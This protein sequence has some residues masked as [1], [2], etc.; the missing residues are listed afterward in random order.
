MHALVVE[1]SLLV[2]AGFSSCGPPGSR[3]QVSGCDLAAPGHVGSSQI[4]DRTHVSCSDR[5][6]LYH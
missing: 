2:M 1:H 4:R 6:I 5:R 3:D